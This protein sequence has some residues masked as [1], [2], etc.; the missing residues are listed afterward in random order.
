MRRVLRKRV[1]RMSEYAFSM[2]PNDNFLDFRLFQYGWEQCESLYSFGPFV[3]NHYLFHY[4]IPG[5][6]FCCPRTAVSP[7]N[8]ALARVKAF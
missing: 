4:V 1:T 8:T 6:E 5:R 2:F 7:I 3:R